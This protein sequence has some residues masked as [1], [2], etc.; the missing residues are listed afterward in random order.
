MINN[1]SLKYIKPRKLDF[2]KT[3]ISPKKEDVIIEVKSCGI[4][5]SDLKIYLG[6]NSSIVKKFT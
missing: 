1:Q 6:N 2:F 4:C 5:G 3:K